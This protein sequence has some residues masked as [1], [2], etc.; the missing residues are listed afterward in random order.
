M[1]VDWAIH[2]SLIQKRLSYSYQSKHHTWSDDFFVTRD[3]Y[4]WVML[5]L[6][7]Y[8]STSWLSNIGDLVLVVIFKFRILRCGW[9]W[10]LGIIASNFLE[11]GNLW[12]IVEKYAPAVVFVGA[13]FFPQF[14]ENF[15][16]HSN[17]CSTLISSK[18]HA[19]IKFE[20]DW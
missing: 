11:T 7:W 10:I 2:A 14:L 18:K 1:Q 16:S 6:I 17:A 19:L 12:A 5:Q 8:Y 9:F 15:R 3:C 13:H 4:N 20:K